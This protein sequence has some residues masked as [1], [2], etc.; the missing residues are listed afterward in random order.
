MKDLGDF[1]TLCTRALLL[2]VSIHVWD[3]EIKRQREVWPKSVCFETEEG[4]S[5]NTFALNWFYFLIV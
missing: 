5:A 4:K 1:K 3:C 2:D